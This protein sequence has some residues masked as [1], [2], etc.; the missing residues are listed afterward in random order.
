LNKKIFQANLIK[1]HQQRKTLFLKNIQLIRV[2]LQAVKQAMELVLL[3]HLQPIINL[4]L[5]QL[6]KYP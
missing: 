1:T 5:Q 4:D 2:V 6:N 3:P